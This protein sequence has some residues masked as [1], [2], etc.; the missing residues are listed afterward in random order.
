MD[1]HHREADYPGYEKVWETFRREYPN[2][3]WTEIS[4]K[5]WLASR[6]IDYLLSDQSIVRIE[7]YHIA[8]IGGLLGSDLGKLFAY[9][10]IR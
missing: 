6:C 10:K 5:G 2:A 8:I 1:S 4:T 3:T 9:K 7:P